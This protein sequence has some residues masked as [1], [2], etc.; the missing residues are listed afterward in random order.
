MDRDILV[1]E[2]IKPFI[3]SLVHVLEIVL[4]ME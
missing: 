2:N 3:K 1:K 4:I